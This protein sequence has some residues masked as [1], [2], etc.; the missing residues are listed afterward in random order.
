MQKEYNKE[1][2]KYRETIEQIRIETIGEIAAL[3]E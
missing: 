2:E 1:K 3:E